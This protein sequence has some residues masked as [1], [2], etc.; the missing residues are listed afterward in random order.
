MPD[1]DAA[2]RN[3]A[4]SLAPSGGMLLIEPGFL[5]VSVAVVRWQWPAIRHD[6]RADVGR[7]C[8]RLPRRSRLHQQTAGANRV[9]VRPG[10]WCMDW[11]IYAH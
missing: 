11:L 5:P 6:D 9:G 7:A 4:A 1:A 3:L 8:H 2:I 10:D